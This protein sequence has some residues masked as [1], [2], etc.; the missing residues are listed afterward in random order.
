MLGE[1]LS[2]GNQMAEK[3]GAVSVMALERVPSDIR[4]QS[5]VARMSDPLKVKEIIESVSI[6]VLSAINLVLGYV[7][8]PKY[9]NAILPSGCLLKGF[10]NIDFYNEIKYNIFVCY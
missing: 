2:T 9:L 10:K 7:C 8:P 1:L 3:A 6:P 5:G 4:A